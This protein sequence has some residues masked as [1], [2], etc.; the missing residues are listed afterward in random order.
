[1]PVRN[2]TPHDPN[3]LNRELDPR[4]RGLLRDDTPH[5]WK[6]N[7]HALSNLS[8]SPVLHSEF[9]DA[10]TDDNKKVVIAR[11]EHVLDVLG[12]QRYLRKDPPPQAVNLRTFQFP[13]VIYVR[14]DGMWKEILGLVARAVAGGGTM[15][16]PE[17]ELSDYLD[18]G[19]E[20]GD[21]VKGS[22]L[23]GCLKRGRDYSET[24]GVVRNNRQ[25]IL[26]VGKLDSDDVHAFLCAYETCFHP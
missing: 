26:N 12:Q 14:T 16:D 19:Y 25:P 15:T 8:N 1:M 4:A 11:V 21:L 5:Y 9:F 3:A 22:Y 13:S 18:A 17:R 24:P 7:I 2:P 6:E 10:L 20:T 23:D